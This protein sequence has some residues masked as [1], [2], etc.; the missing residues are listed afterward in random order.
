MGIDGKLCKSLDQ[1]RDMALTVVSNTTHITSVLALAVT[2]LHVP[3]RL[4]PRIP[5]A[6]QRE[7]CRPLNIFAP[8]AAHVVAV[9][10]FFQFALAARLIGSNRPS[11]R[12]DIAYLFYLP[13]CSLLYRQMICIGAPPTSSHVP[14]RNSSG[15]WTSRRVCAR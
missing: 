10:L 4:H 1:A 6:W 9:E 12:T 11:N 15:A 14:T 3:Q 13:F 2:F 5:E 7:G 8:Y